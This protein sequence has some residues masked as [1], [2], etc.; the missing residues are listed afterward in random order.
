[1]S[2]RVGSGPSSGIYKRHDL[3]QPETRFGWARA[4]FHYTDTGRTGPDPTRQNPRI[5]RKPA[6]TQQTL[7]ETRISD[8]FRSGPSSGIRT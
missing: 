1:M 4:K 8:K 2:G 5:C 3:T 7:S 6:R